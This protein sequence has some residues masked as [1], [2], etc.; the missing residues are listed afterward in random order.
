MVPI[1]DVQLRYLDRILDGVRLLNLLQDAGKG[2]PKLQQ[3]RRHLP[4]GS[5]VDTERAYVR[6]F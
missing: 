4:F 1:C 6:I 2:P 3:L 5:V